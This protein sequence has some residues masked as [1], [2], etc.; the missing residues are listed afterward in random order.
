L[1]NSTIR[2]REVRTGHWLD[3]GLVCDGQA[4][5]IG[6]IAD[7][8]VSYLALACSGLACHDD[9]Q[10][11]EHTLPLQV[12]LGGVREAEEEEGLEGHGGRWL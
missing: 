12:L 7:C 2:D 8:G 4:G 10:G 3:W 5:L 6:I 9:A 1:S 11:R